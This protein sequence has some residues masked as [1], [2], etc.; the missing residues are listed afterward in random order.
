M[1]GIWIFVNVLGFML[2]VGRDIN[3]IGSILPTRIRKG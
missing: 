2:K 3:Y 1:K